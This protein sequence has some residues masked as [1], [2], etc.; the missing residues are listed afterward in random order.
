[1]DERI[2]RLGSENGV[3]FEVQ[4]WSD[5][6]HEAGLAWGDGRLLFE[7]EPIWDAEDGRPLRWTWVD[8]LEFLGRSWPWLILEQDYPL[9]VYPLEPGLFLREAERRWDDMSDDIVEHE[10]ELAHRFIARH[11]LSTG[12]K[13]IFLPSFLLLRQGN[14]FQV[15]VPSLKAIRVKSF[16]EIRSNLEAIGNAIANFASAQDHPRGARAVD[17][18]K[19]RDARLE[20]QAI[21]L[22]SG[23]GPDTR[24][25]IEDN[26]GRAFW[27]QDS[28]APVLE[29]ELLAAARMS[30]GVITVKQQRL[31]LQLIKDAPPV[32][33]PTLDALTSELLS[34]FKDVGRPHNQ[35]Y[36]A[37][38]WL[39]RKLGISTND[40]VCPSDILASWGVETGEFYIEG[41]PLDAIACW[42]ERHGPTVF[43]NKQAGS[44]AHEYGERSTLAHEICHLLLDRQAGL[45]VA[46]VLNGRTPEALEKRARAFAAELLLPREA[47]AH[48]VRMKSQIIEAVDSLNRDYGVS[49]E[50]VCW[51]IQNSDAYS[52]LSQDEKIR[53]TPLH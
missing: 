12:L 34:V 1:M 9:P 3:L 10:E 44:A 20:S 2:Q 28:N 19:S 22:H 26:T 50:L 47:A 49:K 16:N 41:C 37:A 40:R 15:S 38:N 24:K 18:W 32:A 43:L 8:L 42:G 52:T 33:T 6:D 31:V 21:E 51:Q 25:E 35:G 11:D 36:W 30:R 5:K 39:R 48:Y 13:G 7:G 29:T 14:S 17:F 53:L 27:E 46:E 23:L 4:F 45:P